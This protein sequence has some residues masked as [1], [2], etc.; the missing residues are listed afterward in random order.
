M[1]YILPN[2]YLDESPAVSFTFFFYLYIYNYTRI[3]MNIIA[4]Y[5][6]KWSASQWENTLLNQ[7]NIPNWGIPKV[8]ISDRDWNFFSK[9]WLAMFKKLRVNLLYSTTYHLQTDRQSERGNQTLEIALRFQIFYDT[10]YRR[11]N[12]PG[13]LLPKI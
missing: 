9:L 11:A 10:S 1:S 5:Q 6:Q 8:I 3:M 12:W 13:I 4:L 7:L 2:I